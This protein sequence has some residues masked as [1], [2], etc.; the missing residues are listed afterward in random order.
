VEKIVDNL[1]ETM[2][3]NP[4]L[5]NWLSCSLRNVGPDLSMA[6][7][8][9]FSCGTSKK[10]THADPVCAFNKMANYHARLN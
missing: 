1:E 3:A 8:K 5:F 10:K 2:G 4:K 9:S 7:A 6:R